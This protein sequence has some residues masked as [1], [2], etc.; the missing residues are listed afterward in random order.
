MNNQIDCE[1]MEI[2]YRSKHSPL[3]TNLLIRQVYDHINQCMITFRQAIEKGYLDTELFLY[4]CSNISISIHEAFYRGF[5]LGEM[6]TNLTEQKLPQSMININKKHDFDYDII[7]STLT[8]IV[9]SL[10]KFNNTINISDECQLT[11][12]GYIRD[13]RTGKCYILTQAI[14]LGLV[15]FQDNSPL[16]Q[17]DYSALVNETIASEMDISYHEEEFISGQNVPVI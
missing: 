15:S 3:I 5:I 1:E 16:T 17:I 10:S 2:E 8:N 11:V 14:E 6:R 13:K 4:S 12:D 7:F 9:N